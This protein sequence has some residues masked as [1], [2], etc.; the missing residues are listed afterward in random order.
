M[1]AGIPFPYLTLI[2]YPILILLIIWGLISAN[3]KAA[4]MI[5]WLSLGLLLFYSYIF[6]QEIVYVQAYCIPCLI[7]TALIIIILG[8]SL[9]LNKN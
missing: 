2:A 9:S 3:K 1:I 8:I 4:I 7:C 5:K 6:F